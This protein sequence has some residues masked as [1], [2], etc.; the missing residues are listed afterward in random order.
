MRRCTFLL[1]VLLCTACTP[2]FDWLAPSGRSVPFNE[3]TAPP[4]PDADDPRFSV[5]PVFD[6]VPGK[7]ASH[8]PTVAVFEDASLLAAWFSYTGPAELDGSAIFVARRPAG[9]DAWTEP[10]LLV[11]SPAGDGNPVLYAEGDRVWL[12]FVRVPFGWATAQLSLMRSEDRGVTWTQPLAL[13]VGIGTNIKF[14]P[15]RLPGG[16]LLLPAYSDLVTRSLF[17]VSADDGASWTLRS[18]LYTPP[19]FECLQP[20]V[21]RLPGGRLLTV[22]RNRGQSFLWVAVSD[23]EGHTWTPPQ[24]AGFDNPGS[25]AA[26]LRLASGALLLVLNDDPVSRRT[27]SATL[28]RDDG[29]TWTPPRVIVTGAGA[30]SYPALAE[31]ADGLV[32]LVYSH[33]RQRIEH[34]ELNAAWVAGE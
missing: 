24:D 1:A 22:M 27:L 5:R 29:R 23:D 10:M 12:F 18:T 34:V 3:G 28:S 17:L 32:H 25:P 16:E 21:A 2:G 19:P 6:A 14:P 11:D 15:L 30:Y 33:E 8:A 13:P 7:D 26:L 31:G 20:S 4:L 9:A